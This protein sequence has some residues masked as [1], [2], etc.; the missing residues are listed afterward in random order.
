MK[1]GQLATKLFTGFLKFKAKRPTPLFVSYGITG[2]CN[3]KCAFCDWWK[4]NVPE[5]PTRKALAVIDEVC[6]LGVPFFDFSGGEP[7]MRR[8]LSVL[9]KRAASHGCL[10]S[11]NTNG[12][13][14]TDERATEIADSFDVVV[15]SLD[16][17]EELHD[18]NRGMKGT[19]NKAIEAIKM[20]RAHGVKVGV[21]SVLTPWNVEILPQFFEE[22]RGLAD[23][24]EI[25]P[26]HPYPPPHQN[27]PSKEAVSRLITYL[28][29]LKRYDRRF[30]T[31]PTDFIKGFDLF[32]EGKVPKICHA[33]ELYVHIDPLG[34]LLAC[35]P[36]ADI[37]LGDLLTD[38]AAK[39]LKEKQKCEN[40]SKVLSCEGCWLAC[41]VAISMV[42]KNPIKE[43]THFI[44]QLI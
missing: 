28:L 27:K 17:P 31:V 43:S 32:F 18:K 33:G 29:E 19:Y 26:V 10:V 30:L 11:M 5:L 12:S 7:L 35:A 25:Q 24:A 37:V 44:S 39:I 23:F 36:R 20:L 9:A 6:N 3:M 42:F 2:R 41:T 38:S 40:W 14:L 15:V 21:N 8:D 22:L 13:L 1:T 16:G 4:M 34:K